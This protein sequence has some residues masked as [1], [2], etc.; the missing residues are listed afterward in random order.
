MNKKLILLLLTCLLCLS[1]CSPNKK[2]ISYTVYPIGFLIDRISGNTIVNNSIQNDAIIQTAN[3]KENYK[4]IISDSKYF[5]HI[6]K[7]EPYLKIELDEIKTLGSKIVDLS[8]HNA[9]YNFKRYSLVYFN[10]K[11]SFIEDDYYDGEV[12]NDIDYYDKDLYLWLDPSSMISMAKYVL[13]TI[14]LN[15]FENRDFYNSN[16]QKLKEQLIDIDAGYQ[17]LAN[18]LRKENKNIKFVSLSPSFGPWQKAYGFHIYPLILSKYGAIPTDEQLELIIER[19][20][21]DDVKYIV[22]EPNMNSEMLALFDKVEKEL[23]LTRINLS[24]LSSLTKSQLDDGKDYFSIM[25]E[26]LAVLENIATDVIKAKKDLE[27]IH[28]NKEESGN[29]SSTN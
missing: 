15:N 10:D 25:L 2:V 5:F 6:G 1:S 7:L 3:L 13:E 16:Y 4:D 22:Y 27:P 23:K 18:K 9:I 20:K 28:D 17:K 26:N 12:F 24:N 8:L 29:E 14:S 19:I 11:E 21:K